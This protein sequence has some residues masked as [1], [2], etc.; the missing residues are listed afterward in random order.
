MALHIETYFFVTETSSSQD[1]SAHGSC[2]LSMRSA[3]EKLFRGVVIVL[4]IV[5]I[6]MALVIKE[7]SESTSDVRHSQHLSFYSGVTSDNFMIVI[8]MGHSHASRECL[9]Y[10]V[11]L[12]YFA[13]RGGAHL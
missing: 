4:V 12:Q 11:T 7:P 10:C 9:S 5:M 3:A 1:I 8:S 2:L 13:R 6:H